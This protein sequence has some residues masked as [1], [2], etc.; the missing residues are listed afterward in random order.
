MLKKI[1]LLGLKNLLVIALLFAGHSLFSQADSTFRVGIIPYKSKKK[2]KATF[3]PLMEYVGQKLSST[4]SVELMQEEEIGFQLANGE[5]DLGIFTI[6]PYLKTKLEFPELSVTMSH[7]V[8]GNSS[9]TGCIAVRKGEGITSLMDLKG[10]KF[11]FVKS[12]S[13]SGYR[14]PKGI[15]NELGISLDSFF[16]SIDF[17]RNHVK[18]VEML[19][20]KATDGI[21]IDERGFADLI[22]EEREKLELLSNYKIPYHAYVFSPKLSPER[23]E[24]IRQ[25]MLG[26]HKDPKTEE[27]FDNPLEVEQWIPQSDESYNYIRRYLGIIRVPPKVH[28]SYDIRPTA[29][30]RLDQNGDVVSLIKERMMNKLKETRRFSAV[31]LGPDPS[32]IQTSVTMSLIEGRYHYNLYLRDS[33]IHESDANQDELLNE[34]PDEFS[35]ALLNALPIYTE[36]LTDGNQWFVTYGINDGMNLEKYAFSTLNEAGSWYR[37]T[38]KELGKIT[39]LN[40]YLIPN[41][42]FFSGKKIRI[43][44]K[45]PNKKA[46]FLGRDTSVGESGFWDNLDNRWG[47][48]GLIVAFLTLALGSY[49][50]RKKKK[51]FRELLLE[52]NNLLSQY[53]SDASRM[54][55]RLLTLRERA[56]KSLEKGFITEN[57]FLIV[58]HRLDEVDQVLEQYFEVKEQLDPEVKEEMLQILQSEIMTEKSFV[59]IISLLK[60]SRG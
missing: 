58:K 13:T 47:V 30:E 21:A 59:R 16:L 33:L 45:S 12:S 51:R 44:Y 9:Y 50:S 29:K 6:F 7:Q 38:K 40:T 37:L 31:S 4:A 56:T 18:S 26:A 49:L 55:D 42:D 48:V 10:K 11:T 15:F 23:K 19:L 53:I 43:Q 17:S 52:S 8:E 5:L 22:P 28:I 14:I 34:L 60:K 54:D 46:G 2:V 24:E 39:Q 36:I 32:A 25:V 20:A 27:L 1:T 35:H 3:E 41:D 57:Q